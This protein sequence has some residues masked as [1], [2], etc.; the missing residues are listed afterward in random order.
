MDRKV[1]GAVLAMLAL[2]ATGC[3][4]GTGTLSR[5]DFV[6]QANAI[7]KRRTA[8]IAMTEARHRRSFR[9]GV[10][11]ALPLIVKSEEE[12]RALKPPAELKGRYDE[13]IAIE[14]AQLQRIRQALAG[15]PSRGGDPGNELHRQ[16]SLRTELGLGGC[17]V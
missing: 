3:G 9:A 5:A 14:R 8:Q 10:T 2:G 15:H 7:C 16:A 12:L 6:K 17:G 13:L 4:G 1:L 11:A